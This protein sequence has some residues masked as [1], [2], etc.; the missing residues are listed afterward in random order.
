MTTVFSSRAICPVCGE[1][2]KYQEIGSTNAF[3]S[4]DLDTRPPEMKRSTMCYWLVECPECGY[5][6]ENMRRPAPVDKA[7]LDTD[8]YR[9]CDGYS[10]ENNLSKGFY[11]HYLIMKKAGD[12]RSACF[13]LLHTVWGCDD[14]DDDNA[15]AL[16]KILACEL[17]ELLKEE[18]DENID[19]MRMDIL[20]RSKQ[21]A[22]LIEEY[23]GRHF[24][25]EL[26]Y[27]ICKF[28][29]KK[30]EEADDSCYTVDDAI[31]GRS[32]A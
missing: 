16:R 10:F 5:V 9:T 13:A 1:V 21:F 4:M 6:S 29:L 24:D 27:D 30:A 19:I 15:P 17:E 20:R 25:N 32:N 31:R 14:R 26:L 11:R 22:K 18:Y 7:F 12:L 28:Q 3:G 8:A 23:R 2:I